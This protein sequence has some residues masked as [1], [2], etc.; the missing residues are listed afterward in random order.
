MI[1]S[2]LIFAVFLAIWIVTFILM[3]A[4]KNKFLA[5]IGGVIGILLGI[6]IIGEVDRIFGLIA[7]F[8]ALFQLYY[9]AFEG[10]KKT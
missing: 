1:N 8:I 10:D 6:R 3:W 5:G 4:M 2:T 7:I 9:A